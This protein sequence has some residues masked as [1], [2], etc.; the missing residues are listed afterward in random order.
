MERFRE[1]EKLVLEWAEVRGILD[2]A[3]P[4]AQAQK[5]LEEVAELVA[6]IKY[7]DKPEVIDAIGDVTVTLIIQAYLQGVD[8]L[9]CLEGAYNV[10]AKRKGAMV[11]GKYVK[12]S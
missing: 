8:M 5:S 3:T 4:K 11:D 6:A 2:K 12:E 9:D 7:N 10:I 1:L